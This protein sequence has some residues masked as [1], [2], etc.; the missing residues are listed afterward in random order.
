VLSFRVLVITDRTL[1]PIED[2]PARLAAILAAVPRG[3]VAIQIREKDLDGG[4]LLELARNVIA[5]ARPAGALVFIND[6][7]DVALAAGAD[8]VHLP[9]AGLTIEAARSLAPN[10]WIGCS[11][12]SAEAV[13]DAAKRGANLV[14]LGPIFTTPNKG[15]PLGPGLLSAAHPN[16]YLVAVGGIS[17]PSSARDAVRFGADAVAVVRAAWRSRDAPALIRDIAQCVE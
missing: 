4:P 12:H 5:V 17:T 13:T 15:A 1:V 3:H 16:A 9:E 11:R 2:I 8:G 14:Q 10:L 7:L 6:R